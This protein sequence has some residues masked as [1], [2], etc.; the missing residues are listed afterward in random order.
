M[1]YGMLYSSNLFYNICIA[2]AI[3]A[4]Y[5]ICSINP[6]IIAA[7]IKHGKD[8]REM[9]SGNPGLTNTL[10]TMGK[11]AAGLVLLFDVLKGV[12]SIFAVWGLYRLW[13]IQIAQP[14]S[15][16][17]DLRRIVFDYRSLSFFLWIAAL[18]SVL[19]HCYPVYYKFK[20]GKAILVTV[21]TL[22]VIDWLAALILLSLFIIIVVITKYVS[23]GSVIAG[24]LY[25]V[26][27]YVI[28]AYVWKKPPSVNNVG[29]VFSIA[30]AVLLVFKHR[31]NIK[32]L[33]NGTEKKLGRKE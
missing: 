22:F 15:S 20:G 31:G 1:L 10:R 23:L 3:I 13:W 26:V 9:G 25:P 30:V 29:A 28:G 19:G 4:P 14:L 16:Y 5:L 6:A 17:F 7:K 27:V 11:G 32:R 18:S 33:F 24:S 2:F 12:I 21:A 8:I